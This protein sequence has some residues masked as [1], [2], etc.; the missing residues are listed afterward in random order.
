[1]L[2]DGSGSVNSS[3]TPSGGGFFTRFRSRPADHPE[4]SRDQGSSSNV[5]G[6]VSSGTWKP[7]SVTSFTSVSGSR[8]GGTLV[9]QVQIT[10][11][12]SNSSSTGTLTITDL[13]TNAGAVLAISGGATFTNVGIG[14]VDLDSSTEH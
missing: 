4:E 2:L 14:Q 3:G 1:L 12:G 7:R 11:Q 9:L 10:T 5:S 8:S 6:I 13:G